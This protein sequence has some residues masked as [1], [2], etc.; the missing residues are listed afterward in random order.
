MAAKQSSQSHPLI[1]SLRRSPLTSDMFLL[2]QHGGVCSGASES[3]AYCD[4]PHIFNGGIC[5]HA[6][7][8][9]YTDDVYGSREYGYKTHEAQ[10][11]AGI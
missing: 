6:F 2:L 1:L 9:L 4:D 8:I 11:S 3:Q 5:K 10:Q 7:V